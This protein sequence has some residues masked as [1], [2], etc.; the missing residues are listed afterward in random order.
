MLILTRKVNEAIMIGDQ[1]EIMVVE[2]SGDQVKLGI[3]A[4]R[5]IPVY[6]EEVYDSIRRENVSAVY[7]GE[8]SIEQLLKK[9]IQ[10]LE[11]LSED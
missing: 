2:V 1:I 9:G 4:P 8:E 5:D 7:K 10:R 11:D 6:R 3:K